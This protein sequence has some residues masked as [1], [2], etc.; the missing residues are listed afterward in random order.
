[1]HLDAYTLE[2]YHDDALSAEQVAQI[3]SHLRRCVACAQAAAAGACGRVVW[4]RRGLL[5]RLVPV[6]RVA[7]D[8]T[9]ANMPPAERD[10]A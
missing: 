10:A 6:V 9:D 1:M 7:Q 4:E 5:G 3:D 2:R 8:A